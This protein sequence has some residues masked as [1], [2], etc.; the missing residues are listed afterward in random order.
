[1]GLLV[2]ALVLA[3]GGT[4]RVALTLAAGAALVGAAAGAS[5]YALLPKKPLEPTRRRL[6]GDV[7]RLKE[8]I[9]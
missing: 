4:A 6:M 3:L 1:M 8:H 7:D 2:M 9:A 5:G